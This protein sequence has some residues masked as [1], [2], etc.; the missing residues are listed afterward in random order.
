MSVI[1]TDP[2]PPPYTSPFLSSGRQSIYDQGGGLTDSNDRSNNSDVGSLTI[3]PAWLKWLTDSAAQAHSAYEN[4]VPQDGTIT[5]DELADGSVTTQ[6][7]VDEAITNVKLAI[8]AVNALNIQ[9]GA[10]TTTKVSDDAITTP[11]LIANAVTAAKIAANTIT[12]AQIQALTITAAEIAAGTITVDKLNVA[13]LSAITANLGTV[14]AGSIVGLTISGG[15]ITGT[16]LQTAASNDRVVIDSTNGVQ[17]YDASNVLQ[18]QMKA[19]VYAGIL[20]S[21]IRAMTS[22]QLFLECQDQSVQLFVDQ[23]NA[24]VSFAIAGASRGY[25][26]ASDGSGAGNQPTSLVV[27]VNGALHRVNYNSVTSNLFI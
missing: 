5:S 2:V 20:V 18:V 12:A 21:G 16:T 6:K 27:R 10:V 19:S 1:I 25:F 4:P 11:K 22:A 3:S 24:R 23:A 9:D 17:I 14:T 26:D 13:T 15:T 8:D 7:L